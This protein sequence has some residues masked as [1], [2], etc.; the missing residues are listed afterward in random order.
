MRRVGR[1]DLSTFDDQLLDGLEF[2]KLVYE[3]FDQIKSSPDGLEQLRLLT[4]KDAKKLKEELI[5]IARYVQARYREGRRIKVRWL[6]G[7]QPYDAVLWSFGDSIKNSPVS[8]RLFVEVTTSVHES[9][10]LTRELLHKQGGSFGVLGTFRD[11]KTKAIISKAHAYNHS[12]IAPDLAAQIID[13]LERKRQKN[14][15][16]NTVLI[17]NCITN[18][19]TGEDEWNDA[20]ALVKKAQVHI[21]FREVFLLD[22]LLSNSATFYGRQKRGWGGGPVVRQKRK[23]IP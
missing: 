21:F 9:E 17:V 12:D 11:K 1:V 19:L 23:T 18:G 13:R 15:P 20:I 6:S 22:M 4:T 2:C 16:S 3:M 8:R 14:Y 7:S 5:P 10:H